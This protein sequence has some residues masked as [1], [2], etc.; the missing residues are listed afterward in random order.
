MR[1]GLKLWSTNDF[2][3]K[4]AL[5]LFEKGVYDYIELY[6]V[7]GSVG[8]LELWRELKIPFN[9]HAP[10]SFSG[11][12][13]AQKIC[14]SRN[15]ELIEQVDEYRKVLDP[16]YII[17]HPGLDGYLKET[18][19][20]FFRIKKQYSEIFKIAVVENKPSL[21]IDGEKCI[22][23]MPEE[24][25]EI[26]NKTGIR[27]CLDIGHAICTAT[28]GGHDFMGMIH[29]FLKL[30]PGIYHLSDGIT[31][32]SR[33]S[34]LNYGTGD[35]PL[36]RILE[37]LSKNAVMTV[38]TDKASKENLNDFKKDIEYIREHLK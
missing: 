17:F 14:E 31:E 11:L 30:S 18:L 33:D 22:G 13:L 35:Y 4:P 37:L 10:H 3:I 36:Q 19:R 32:S 6:I 1:F 20:Q 9:L 15:F 27:F 21:G 7:P 34:H 24:I 12:N 38:E 23:S 16:E 25:I 26:S 29:S 5:S 2:Y 28:D 8:L